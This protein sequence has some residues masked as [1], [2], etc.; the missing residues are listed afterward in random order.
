MELAPYA[1]ADEARLYGARAQRET[2][3]IWPRTQEPELF[4]AAPRVVLLFRGTQDASCRWRPTAR[5]AR[6]TMTR[7]M[8]AALKAQG[9]VVREA[10]P[11][12][13]R[14]TAAVLERP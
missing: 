5:A 4:S 7:C 11:A 13:R 9:Y 6:A 12:G 2:R 10:T 3:S 1:R 14:W 8:P